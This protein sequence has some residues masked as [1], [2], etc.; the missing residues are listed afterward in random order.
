[1]AVNHANTLLNNSLLS[2]SLTRI[3]SKQPGWP[4][5][6]WNSQ[7]PQTSAPEHGSARKADDPWPPCFLTLLSP[8]GHWPTRSSSCA[9]HKQPPL[10]GVSG[11]ASQQPGLLPQRE[12]RTGPGDRIKAIGT[13]SS[14]VLGSRS[15]EGGSRTQARDGRVPSMKLTWTGGA[16]AKA[17]W[18]PLK[19]TAK[20]TV[21]LA[22]A[23]L[24]WVAQGPNVGSWL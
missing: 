22:E 1:M 9:P 12:A 2:S 6:S 13:G 5:S 24:V 10:P 23:A 8:R 11:Y 3:P 17:K 4:G 15:M 19:C 18:S 7:T 20:D 16:E 14:D 21:A